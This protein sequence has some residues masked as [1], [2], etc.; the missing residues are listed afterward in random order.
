MAARVAARRSDDDS[1]VNKGKGP[2]ASQRTRLESL[3]AV[4]NDLEM[5]G[6]MQELLG[7]TS[8]WNPVELSDLSECDDTVMA[9]SALPEHQS[10]IDNPAKLHSV[11]FIVPS[12]ACTFLACAWLRC[13]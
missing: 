4:L 11:L 7:A 6:S 3:M 13:A 10:T 8:S 5:K 2:K 9:I 12:F 1:K